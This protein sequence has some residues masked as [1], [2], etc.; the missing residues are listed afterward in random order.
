M[1]IFGKEVDEAADIMD[2]S[3]I[4]AK[5]FEGKGLTL[6]F[7]GVEK[8]KSQYG[9][10]ADST[11][12]EKNI[13]E[14]G[15]QFLF[16]FKDSEGLTRKHYSTSMPFFI[17]MRKDRESEPLEIAE[18]DW[19]VIRREGVKDKTRYYVEKTEVSQRKSKKA[20]KEEN[21]NDDVPF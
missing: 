10:E 4:R 20:S 21:S 7:V 16:T 1:S 12:V 11:I 18:G 5:E 6:Q 2:K 15:E 17:G 3:K 14:E 9:A 8:I 13:L 19:L